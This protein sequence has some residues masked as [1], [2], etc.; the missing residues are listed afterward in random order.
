MRH[1]FRR[2]L[3]LLTII[4]LSLPG[5]LLSQ[6]AKEQ[7]IQVRF[8]DEKAQ[9]SGRSGRLVNFFGGGFLG[10]G[11]AS[12]LK[13]LN[14]SV[15]SLMESIFYS[16]LDKEFLTEFSDEI[17]FG[18]KYERDLHETSLG[19]YIVVDSFRIGPEFGKVIGQLGEFPIRLGSTSGVD[20]ATITHRNTAMRSAESEQLPFWRSWANEWFGVLPVLSRILPPS[21]NPLQMYDPVA[22]A[23]TPLLFPFSHK[24]A[25]KMPIGSIRSIGISGGLSIT[26]DLF[27]PELERFR[28][29]MRLEDLQLS[30]PIGVFKSGSHRINVLRKSE[31]IVWV[32]ITDL[33]EKGF[34]SDWD[35]R[36]RY[37]AFSK[38]IPVWQGMPVPVFPID[39][40]FSRLRLK[41]FDQVFS[42]DLRDKDAQQAYN[43]IV[44]GDLRPTLKAIDTEIIGIRRLFNRHETAKALRQKTSRSAFVYNDSRK[45][46]LRRSLVYLEDDQRKE[47][48][49]E[50]SQEIQDSNWNVLVGG[51]YQ[52]FNNKLEMRV[53][54]NPEDDSLFFDPEDRKPYHLRVNFQINDRYCNSREFQD[55]IKTARFVSLMPLDSLP[56]IPIYA[57]DEL[58]EFHRR[59]LL[60]DP[61][62]SHQIT[63][64]PPTLL[65]RL[66]LV[67]QMNF[68]YDY[69]QA[70]KAITR[71]KLKQG[72]YES[73]RGLKL[74]NPGEHLNLASYLLGWLVEP[75]SLAN[76]R[77]KSLKAE[78]EFQRLWEGLQRY[79]M[80]KTPETV[81]EALEYVLD[82]DFPGELFHTF[83]NLVDDQT[84]AKQF[85]MQAHSSVKTNDSVNTKTAKQDFAKLNQFWIEDGPAMPDSYL[86]AYLDSDLSS[87]TPQGMDQQT[88]T[89]TITAVTFEHLGS[90]TPEKVN[91]E[92]TVDIQQT[93][94]NQ[95]AVYLYLRLEQSGVVDLGRFMVG[96]NSKQLPMIRSHDKDDHG[97]VRI[98][99]TGPKSPLKA[100]LFSDSFRI[101]G[102]YNLFLSTSST[103]GSWSSER[104]I[105]IVVDQSGKLSLAEQ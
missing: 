18:I 45:Q 92:M 22:L 101:E 30:L 43:A 79:R 44:T 24:K 14:Q 97:Q 19:G 16:L 9:S 13:S 63:P 27:E 32:G 3:T 96:E 105:P 77:L 71:A 80:A 99:L 39:L 104:K 102:R 78:R 51:E 23:T 87:F 88:P 82:T 55:A 12:G 5:N 85:G 66:N 4:G 56:A 103:G 74:Q 54:K 42:F 72:I 25:L 100:G 15:D 50:I 34:Q 58:R 70:L 95:D 52:G 64:V 89:P 17:R 75:L 61:M 21:F 6:P 7:P 46:R 31:H 98:Y 57:E 38:L 84:V 29:E 49:I 62:D 86:S 37:H 59:N 90:T 36:N 93:H 10:N 65:G 48:F 26:A 76:I 83:L 28:K 53:K 11:L 35:L 68:P 33:Q 91:I 94:P 47:N 20:F 81:G 2:W 8:A 60:L 67:L 73:F 69:L 40:F 1:Q 41:R